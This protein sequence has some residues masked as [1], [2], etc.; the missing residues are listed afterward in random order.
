MMLFIC[1]H[2]Q[3][4][5]APSKPWR[6]RVFHNLLVVFQELQGQHVINPCTARCGQGWSLNFAVM[7][8]K[9]GFTIPS[10]SHEGSTKCVWN[11]FKASMDRWKELISAITVRP[12][13]LVPPASSILVGGED[14]RLFGWDHLGEGHR[15]HALDNDMF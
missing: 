15:W 3:K 9:C 10:K 1:L 6:P 14:L 12:Q 7:Q 8:Y 2:Q 11:M 4:P 5:N 13:L